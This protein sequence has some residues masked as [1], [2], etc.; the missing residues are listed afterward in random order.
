ML[1][2][3]LLILAG[4]LALALRLVLRVPWRLRP[5]FRGEALGTPVE[6]RWPD[7]R[8]ENAHRRIEARQ[9]WRQ[10]G[11]PASVYDYLDL[12]QKKIKRVRSAEIAAASGILDRVSVFLRW[13]ARGPWL[14]IQA[15][16]VTREAR[17]FVGPEIERAKADREERLRRWTEQEMARRKAEAERS[18][19]ERLREEEH[20]RRAWEQRQRRAREETRSGER[21]AGRDDYAEAVVLLGLVIPFTQKAFS[22]AYRRAMMAAHPDAGGTTEA[23]QAVNAARDLIRRRNGW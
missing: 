8:I 23:A 11:N 18:E 6:W 2:D 3:A 15:F 1:V 14:V 10:Q 16:F 7:W 5:R 12:V 4:L 19:A 20:R 17:E 9:R 13:E 21:G 22:K